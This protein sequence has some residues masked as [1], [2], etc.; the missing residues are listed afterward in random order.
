LAL[1][2]LLVKL[3]TRA[4]MVPSP[5]SCWWVNRNSSA[6]VQMSAPLPATVCTPPLSLQLPAAATAPTSWLTQGLAA[7]EKVAV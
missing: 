4:T 7:T 2:A 3:V 5:A 1:P 6:V